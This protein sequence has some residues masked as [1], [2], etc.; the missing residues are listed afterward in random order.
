VT[1]A[2]DT[3][4]AFRQALTA[5]LRAEAA[6]RR[7]PVETLRTKVLIERLLAR[8]FARP[9]PPWLL[10]GGYAFE[11]RYRPKARTTRDI[12]LSVPRSRIRSLRMRLD[13]VRDEIQQA[14]EL[15]LGD[16]LQFVVGSLRGELRGPP[17]GGGSF[18][19]EAR[20]AGKPYGHFQID[21]AFGD[22]V[23]GQP[24]E[25]VGDNLL[26]FAGVRPARVSVVSEAQQFAEKV[27]AYTFPWTDR[28][29]TRVKD[30][31]DLLLLVERGHLDHGELHKALEATFAARKR[32]EVPRVLPP[33]PQNWAAEYRALALDASVTPAELM[34]AFERLGRFWK[35]LMTGR[36]E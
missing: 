25:L 28:E 4:Q 26:A 18:P 31:V 6:K 35:E 23:T 33:P 5:R 27:H 7:V 14:A 10:K 32:Q 15:D 17:L 13:L 30:L 3:P 22:A 16:H 12:D 34:P 2:F 9:D 20:I 24:V 1:R 21:V 11:L 36:V 19:V 8:L 29:N